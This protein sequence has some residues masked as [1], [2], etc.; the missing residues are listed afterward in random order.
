[1]VVC[2]ILVSFQPDSIN[3][4]VET[5]HG[6]RGGFACCSGRVGD[7]H[8]VHLEVIT[9]YEKSGTGIVGAGGRCVS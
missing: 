1:M 2:R 7:V 4:F 9:G 3:T 8:V 5:S 6:K